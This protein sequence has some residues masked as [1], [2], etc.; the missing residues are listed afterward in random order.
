MSGPASRASRRADAGLAAALLLLVAAL[1]AP[2]RAFPFVVYDDK[3]L[4]VE[5]PHVAAGL[6]RSSIAWA[7]TQAYA[8]NY[9]PLSWLSHMLDVELFGLDPGGHHVV[10]AALHAAAMLLLFAA[11][12]RLGIASAPAAFVAACF[13]VHPTRVES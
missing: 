7:F 3:H 4:V 1:Y 13:G 5:N 10:N 12:R 11:L 6:E 2:V 9:T 8:G